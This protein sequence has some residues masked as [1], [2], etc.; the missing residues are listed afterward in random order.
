MTIDGKDYNVYI[1]RGGIDMGKVNIKLGE[2][3]RERGLSK[4]KVCKSC[5]IQ[6][7]QL[8]RYIN[9]DMARVDLSILARLCDYLECDVADLLGYEKGGLEDRTEKGLS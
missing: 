1:E 4:N 2:L 8:N 5:D 3:M 9:N 6:R 7:S